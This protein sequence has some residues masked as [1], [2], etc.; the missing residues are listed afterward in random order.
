MIRRS[1]EENVLLAQE[2]IRD[3]NKSN[4]YHNLMVQLDIMKA[5]DRISWVFLT[6]V[7][8]RFGFTERI[9]HVVRR[10]MSNN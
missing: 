9:I 10:L 6:K 1:I 4:Q 7:M 8:R 2:I 3:I 5:Y